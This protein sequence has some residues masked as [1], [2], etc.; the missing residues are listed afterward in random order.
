MWTFIGTVILIIMVI[1]AFAYSLFRINVHGIF[2]IYLSSVISLVIGTIG[3]FQNS[4]FVLAFF[5]FT[6]NVFQL[7][8]DEKYV[9]TF[10]Q[11]VKA[12]F[13]KYKHNKKNGR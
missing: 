6:F 4:Y 2:I 9:F 3:I 5:V 7:Y 10:A 12:N 8:L 13:R 11:F 1:G